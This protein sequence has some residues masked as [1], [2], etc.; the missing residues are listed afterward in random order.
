M[1]STA[2]FW[3]ASDTPTPYAPATAGL[4]VAA[5]VVAAGY[6]VVL[7]V[8]ALRLPAGADLTGQFGGQPVVKASA[9]V[10]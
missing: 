3:S 7:I 1:A 10:L 6:G 4:W 9:A 5:A 8:A 2:G